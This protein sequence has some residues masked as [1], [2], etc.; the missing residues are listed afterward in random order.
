MIFVFFVHTHNYL[1]TSKHRILNF[2]IINKMYF[3]FETHKK[4]ANILGH[5]EKSIIINIQEWWT[6]VNLLITNL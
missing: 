6:Q 4:T 1:I 2:T 3:A 5:K